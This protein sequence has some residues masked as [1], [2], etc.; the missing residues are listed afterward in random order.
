MMRIK[1]EI[2]RNKPRSE[3]EEEPDEER[4][5]EITDAKHQYSL[6]ELV[7]DKEKYRAWRDE[8]MKGKRS[9]TDSSNLK[10]REGDLFEGIDGKGQRIL[11]QINMVTKE[12]AGLAQEIFKRYPG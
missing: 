2:D 8:L 1:K 10:K 11:H 12:A 5:V 4:E 3:D 9:R 6:R 7:E